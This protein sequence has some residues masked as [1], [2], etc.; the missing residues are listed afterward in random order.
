MSNSYDLDLSHY[1]LDD[2]LGLFKLEYP[3]NSQSLKRAKK[4]AMR[5]HPDKSGL[6]SSLF[7]FFSTAY[8]TLEHLIDFQNKGNRPA[9]TQYSAAALDGDD[10]AVVLKD[11]QDFGEIFNHL[12][13]SHM[14]PLYKEDGHGAWLASGTDSESNHTNASELQ[15]RKKEL[16]GLVVQNE[17]YGLASGFGTELCTSSQTNCSSGTLAFDDVRKA[18]TETVIPVTDADFQTKRQHG[19]VAALQRFRAAD[20]Q[21]ISLANHTA[22]LERQRQAA[23]VAN[24]ELAF[25]LENRDRSMRSCKSDMDAQLLLLDQK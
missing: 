8:K 19:N 16:R 12:F 1:T 23:D 5:M 7:M 22:I 11:R 10:A 9:E 21:S 24:L 14:Q 17:V 13:E 6:D 18:Y 25:E 3:L 4:I 15:A 20:M 2:L